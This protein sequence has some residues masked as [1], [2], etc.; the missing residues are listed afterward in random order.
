MV[1]DGLGH[2]TDEVDLVGRDDLHVARHPAALGLAE[3]ESHRDDREHVHA[4]DDVFEERNQ[5]ILRS[6]RRGLERS[7]RVAATSGTAAK[8]STSASSAWVT[9]AARSGPH[10]S[11]MQSAVCGSN[12]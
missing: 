3:M 4:V 7:R 8:D 2:R 1:G 6:A 11:M 9:Q 5:G 10:A 12:R